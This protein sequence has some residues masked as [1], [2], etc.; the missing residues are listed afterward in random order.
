MTEQHFRIAEVE[1]AKSP[2]DEKILGLFQFNGTG[3]VK[4]SNKLIILAEI[5]STLYAYERFLDVINDTVERTRHLIAK[6][7]RDPIARFEKL[8]QRVN[9]AIA[10]FLE[11][12][13]TPITW[14]RV[15]LFLIELSP[16][17]IC[18]AGQGRLMNMFLQKQDDGTY[19]SFDLLGSLEQPA[20]VDPKKFFASLICGDMKSGDVLMLGSTNLERLRKELDMKTRLTD[21]PPVTAALEI[22]NDLEA[23]GIPDDFLAAI[24][25]CCELQMPE[26]AK[27]EM[28]EDEEKSTASIKELRNTEKDTHQKLAPSLVPSPNVKPSKDRRARKPTVPAGFLGA[29]KAL[30][31]RLGRMRK[32]DAAL[33]TSLRG[34]SAGHG[35]MFTP[36][37]K[38]IMIIAGVILV[39]G[40]GTVFFW[41]RSQRIA[42]EATAW[43]TTFDEATDNR[44]RAESDLIYA[45]DE[46]AASYLRKADELLASLPQESDEQVEKVATLRGELDELRERL[47]KIHPADSVTELAALTDAPSGSLRAPVLTSDAAYVVDTQNRE[48]LKVDLLN[49]TIKTLPLP[50]GTGDV[51]AGSQSDRSVI[52]ATN[53]GEIYS[54]NK[55]TDDVAK[56]SFTPQ[57][58]TTSDLV[59]YA[60]RAYTLDPDGG[61]IYRAPSITGGFSS[62]QAYIQA[63]NISLEGAIGLAIDS[64]VYVLKPDGTVARYASG[65]QEGFALATV[66][67][68]LK[69][70]SG[71]WT[72]QDAT[73]IAI[74]D[75]AENRILLFNK[76][77]SLSAQVTSDDFSSLRDIDADETSKRMIVVDGTR[78]LLV[79]MP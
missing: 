42:A 67:P 73:K 64:N 72:D 2:R 56:A 28:E 61:Q 9:D 44:H 50:D 31:G 70:A 57:S 33:M 19:R 10:E 79:P 78:L 14:G 35:S 34:M 74:T 26:A 23:R 7:E 16:N 68:E 43:N 75:P 4:S 41:K 60:N 53:N 76:D 77:G 65:G 69:A 20:E 37:R 1:V 39:V 22:K 63:S 5:S 36:K 27:E 21:L 46:R 48:V 8:I 17:H 62:G 58:D 13:P 49:T 38:R 55:Q 29:I 32:K 52:F 66:D 3:N 59:I 25:S 12:E 11:G 24:I 51:I 45:N 6:V 40:L 47:R 18:L 30:Q 71:I 15:S 54:I